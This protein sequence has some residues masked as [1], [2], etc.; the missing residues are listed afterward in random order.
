MSLE[1]TSQA[2]RRMVPS[3]VVIPVTARM[4]PLLSKCP[5]YRREPKASHSLSMTRM[6]PDP[7]LQNDL[8]A[9]V[10]YNIPPRYRSA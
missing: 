2:F 8:G 9:L 4:L 10:L 7:K 6:P 5:V 1:I 3:P